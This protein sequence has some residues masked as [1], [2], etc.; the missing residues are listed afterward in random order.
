MPSDIVGEIRDSHP[1]LTPHLS[2]NPLSTSREPVKKLFFLLLQ[3]PAGFPKGIPPPIIPR[4]ST[5]LR[6]AQR[7]ARNDARSSQLCSS[8]YQASVV[9]FDF[10]LARDS[11]DSAPPCCSDWASVS[12]GMIAI[13]CVG[14][15]RYR[16]DEP[17]WL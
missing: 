14:G 16:A 15:K 17:A 6:R 10:E 13:G 4:Y 3:A 11:L 1:F 9:S 8:N 2:V 7:R 12:G 5:A